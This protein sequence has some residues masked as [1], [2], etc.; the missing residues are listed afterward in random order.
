MAASVG[1]AAER[2]AANTKTIATV[3]TSDFRAVVVARRNSGGRAPTAAVTID[4]YARS[5]RL[6]KPVDARALRRS[7]L[8]E[9]RY[10]PA[11]A[12]QLRDR[13]RSW[14]RRY[15]AACGCPVAAQ[16]VTW[17]RRSSN[18]PDS[19]VVMGAAR[20]GGARGSPGK[21]RHEDVRH[22]ADEDPDRCADREPARGPA[23]SSE[24]A[25]SKAELMGSIR[26]VVRAAELEE[27]R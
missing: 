1:S 16:P 11:R 5:G 17:L 10:R 23:A 2:A 12:L 15:P 4:T 20:Y 18:D 25:L 27:V 26:G 14:R 3:S 7:V 13:V 24:P 19:C 21:E 8:L 9:H 22:P 6:W